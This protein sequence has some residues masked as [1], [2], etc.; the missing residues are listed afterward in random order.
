MKKI[1]NL[2]DINALALP[3]KVLVLLSKYA[4]ALKSSNGMVIKLSSLKVF[5]YVHQTCIQAR[6]SQLNSIYHELLTEVNLHIDAGTMFTNKEKKMLLGRN[7]NKER[8]LSKYLPK[9]STATQ[10]SSKSSSELTF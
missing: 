6:N 3:A 8:T 5:Y 2:E 4:K 9:S 1:K 7:K 10:A